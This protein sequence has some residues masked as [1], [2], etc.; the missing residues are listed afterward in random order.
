[1]LNCQVLTE[2]IPQINQNTII[3]VENEQKKLNLFN[4]DYLIGNIPFGKDGTQIYL[5]FQPMQ[6]YFKTVAGVCNGSYTYYWISKG[7]SEERINSI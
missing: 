3:L 7:L 1:M 2:N 6:V 5:A 4:W